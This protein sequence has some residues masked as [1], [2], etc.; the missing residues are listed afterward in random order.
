[1]RPSARQDR[2]RASAW[3]NGEAVRMALPGGELTGIIS[4]VAVRRGGCASR[5][6]PG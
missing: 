3:W 1:M 2:A 5:R 6:I 4:R